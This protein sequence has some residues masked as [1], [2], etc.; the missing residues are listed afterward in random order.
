MSGKRG[1]LATHSLLFSSTRTFMY[2][3]LKVISDWFLLMSL[4]CNVSIRDS[5]SAIMADEAVPILPS[6]NPYVGN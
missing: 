1:K 2:N 5:Q 4:K 6:H 3:V